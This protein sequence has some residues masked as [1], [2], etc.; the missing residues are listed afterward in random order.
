MAAA[1]LRP[2]SAEARNNL[3]LILVKAALRNAQKYLD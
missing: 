2:R 3:G 1:A